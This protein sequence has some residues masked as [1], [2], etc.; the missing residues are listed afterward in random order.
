MN[1]DLFAREVPEGD[2]GAFSRGWQAHFWKGTTH[3][4]VRHRVRGKNNKKHEGPAW[5]VDGRVGAK[6]IDRWF[7]S[8]E[9]A[10]SYAQAEIG[11]GTLERLDG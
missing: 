9:A 11:M 8:L 4:Y 5:P 7:Y 3:I 1:P 10:M 2:P 6:R